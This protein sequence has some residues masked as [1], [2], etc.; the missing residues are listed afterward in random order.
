MSISVGMIDDYFAA[1][2]LEHKDAVL[3]RSRRIARTNLRV[4]DE[5]MQT[6]PALDWVKPKSGTTALVRLPR[7]QSS[8]EFAVRLLDTTGVMVTPGSAMAM[9]GWLRIG[10]ANATGVVRAGLERM[11]SFLNAS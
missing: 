2:A 11:S 1:L 10:Y 8:R 3:A 9:E 6:E 4:L 5:W 7:G